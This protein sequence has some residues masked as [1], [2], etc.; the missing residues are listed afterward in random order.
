ML[1]KFSRLL[2]AGTISAMIFSCTSDPL[3]PG[4][5]FM[6]DMYR[7]PSYETYG[8]NPV[9]GDSMAARM[10]VEGTVPRGYEPFPYPNTDSG[11][12]KAGSDMVNPVALTPEVLEEGKILYEKFCV[13]CHGA[14]G[15]ADGLVVTNGGFP[16]PPAYS[17]ANPT[18]R[19]KLSMNTLKPGHIYHT[20]MYGYNVMGSHAAQVAQ[21]DRWK[22][23]YYVQKLQQ[24]K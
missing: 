22:I 8:E 14:T 2:T 15:K 4:H 10:P 16:P 5:E 3:S 12:S 23:I 18:R 1:L 21:A 7:S 9:F 13:H 24:E 17:D 6:P 20:I 19:L 11:F